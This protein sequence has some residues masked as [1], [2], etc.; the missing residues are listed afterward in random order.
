MSQ[1][2]SAETAAYNAL[3][4]KWGFRTR[5]LLKSSVA[6]LTMKGKKELVTRIQFKTKKDFG[7]TEAAIFN[8]PQHGVFFHKG[9][10]R[11][12]IM[13][14]GTVVR[15]KRKDKSHSANSPNN[16]VIHPASGPLN[17]HPKDWFNPVFIKAI[18]LL[19]DI[20]A[21]TKADHIFD[22]KN[23]KLNT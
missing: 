14:A 9:V 5:N 7:E 18:P 15:G 4:D 19:A 11:G 22:I 3:I 12:Y 21:K 23:L 1:M 8:F 20:I 16:A 6:K 13:V 10:G 2:S 17:R